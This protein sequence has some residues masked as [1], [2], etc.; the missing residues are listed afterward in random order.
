MGRT[1]GEGKIS[2][3]GRG[4]SR[5]LVPSSGGAGVGS[6]FRLSIVTGILM[7]LPVLKADREGR[8]KADRSG[9]YRIKL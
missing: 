8:Q 2:D 7:R 5:F 6:R 4:L 3:G 1:Q 9:D